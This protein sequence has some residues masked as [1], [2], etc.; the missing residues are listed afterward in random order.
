[1]SHE[2]TGNAYLNFLTLTNGATISLSSTGT[3]RGGYD[4]DSPLWTVTGAGRSTYDG[5]LTLIAKDKG[6][7]AN[8]RKYLTIDVEDTVAGDDTD[9]LLAGDILL[10]FKQFKMTSFIKSG[11]GTMEIDGKLYTTNLPVQVTGGTLLLSQSGATS[12]VSFSLEGG[13]LA[14][15]A[16]TANSADAFALT[17][18]STLSFGDGAVISLESLTI[19]DGATLT[20]AGNVPSRGLRVSSDPG[21]ETLGRIVFADG[22]KGTV[23]WDSNG[24][25]R[26]KGKGLIISIH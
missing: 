24:Y 5:D 3:F 19:P 26:A 23:V 4:V 8:S 14:L 16:G 10:D 13:T 17:A 9:F 2:T 22:R 6:T 25:V 1:M 20:L 12:D 7:D 15:A 18:D 11:A 21:E